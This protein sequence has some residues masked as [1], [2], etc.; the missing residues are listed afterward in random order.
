MRARL[1]LEIAEGEAKNI[2]LTTSTTHPPRP[3]LTGITGETS[4]PRARLSSLA[5][6]SPPPLLYALIQIFGLYHLPTYQR[7]CPPPQGIIS[8]KTSPPRISLPPADS[9]RTLRTPCLFRLFNFPK[10]SGIDQALLYDDHSVTSH[11]QIRGSIPVLWS[12]PTNLRYRPKV[13]IDPD[14]EAS[15]RALRWAVNV[16]G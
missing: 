9:L 14:Q 16:F 10:P 8:S 2:S 4:V 3:F 15:L 11:V 13:R 12:S 1:C 7:A 6:I 5:C